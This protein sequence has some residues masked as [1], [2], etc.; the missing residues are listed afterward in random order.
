MRDLSQW[1]LEFTDNLEDTEAPALGHTFH[2]SDSERPTEVASMKHSIHTH[3]RQDRNCEVCKRTKM[4]RAP[5][6]KRTGEAPLPAEKFGG[7]ITEDHKVLHEGGE[8]RNNHR[9]AVAVQDLATQWIQWYPC[10]TKTSQD[11]E[12]SLRKFLDPSLKPKVIY[13][14]NSFEFWHIL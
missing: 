12:K 13:T 1:L 6:R 14:D 11:T 8:Y 9:Y 10:K 5:C 7:L 4:T 2:D 3:F